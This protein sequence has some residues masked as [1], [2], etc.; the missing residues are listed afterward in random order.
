MSTSYDN[1]DA[2]GLSLAERI[3]YIVEAEPSFGRLIFLLLKKID[4]FQGQIISPDRLFS[5]I[6]ARRPD[7]IAV[8][9]SPFV[10]ETLCESDLCK[11]L[12][13][14]YVKDGELD[15]TPA[16]ELKK[17]DI[18]W[19][20]KNDWQDLEEILKRL[21]PDRAAKRILCVDDSTTILNQISR[22]FD[23]TPYSV[24]RAANGHDALKILDEVRPDLILTD[25]EMPVM[26]GL[27]FCRE[28]RKNADSARTPLIILSSR[29]DHHTM[30]SGFDAGADEYLTK[31]FFP[32]ELL[33]KVESYLSPLPTRRKE[34]IVAVSGNPIVVHALQSALEQQGFDVLVAAD[35]SAVKEEVAREKPDMVISEAELPGMTGF[36]LCDY[37]RREQGLKRI[38]FVITTGKTSTGARRLGQ[39]VGVTAY[40]TKPFTR[41]GLVM[42]VERLLAEHRSLLALERDMVLASITSLAKALDERD[43]YT[44][45]HSGN[46]ARYAVAIGR[47][48]GLNSVETESLRLAGLLHDIGKIGV[49]DKILHKPGRLTLEEFEKVKEHSFRG[50]EILQPIPSLDGVIPAILHHHERFDGGGYP[51]G[52]RGKEIPAAAQILAV[53]DTY[54]ALVTDRPYRKGMPREKAV[55]IMK[56]V[57]GSQLSPDYV[58]L[59]LQW[60]QE[61]S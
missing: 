5:A 47:A 46:V 16:P 6:R 56:E 29:I 7:F 59:F 19:T 28:V 57:S 58:A 49:P 10:Y 27:T 30:A 51:E 24:C 53:A 52:L 23:G 26:D 8:I 60:L 15:E 42:L 3:A 38:P 35:P 1:Q 20:L 14:L 41:E 39:K 61:Q 25:V 4:G 40:L 45:F 22:A 50:A 54:D 17:G 2:A 18:S 33:N 43:S 13:V 31:P 32:D 55:A 11:G 9:D 44:R 37:L 12:P 34:R 21:T 48:A 36:E